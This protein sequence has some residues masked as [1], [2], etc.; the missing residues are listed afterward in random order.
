M[1]VCYKDSL[2]L[3]PVTQTKEI[4][5]MIAYTSLYR[6]SD[7]KLGKQNTVRPAVQTVLRNMSYLFLATL[8]NSR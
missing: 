8:P 2:F 3:I 6:R 4:A 5:A 7:S 1:N